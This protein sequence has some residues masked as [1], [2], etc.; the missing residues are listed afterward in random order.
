MKTLI[1]L[2]MSILLSN[3]SNAQANSGSAS[4]DRF[5]NA[6]TQLV[7]ATSIKEGL[8]KDQSCSKKEFSKVNLEAFV[9]LMGEKDKNFSN[10]EQTKFLNQ[11]KG[12]IDESLKAKLPDGKTIGQMNYEAI[13][14]SIRNMQKSMSGVDFCET[15]NKTAEG[16]YQKAMDN[17]RLIPNK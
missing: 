6:L 17:I 2:L 12:T 1:L 5:T 7:G 3:S 15:V 16:L 11:L 13:A 9:S 8:S 14:Q 10:E 4:G